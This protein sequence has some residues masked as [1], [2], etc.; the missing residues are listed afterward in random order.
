MNVIKL[1]I[2]R[3]LFMFCVMAAVLLLGI[4]L[5][6][7]VG[8]TYGRYYTNINQNVNFDVHSKQAAY[9][10]YWDGGEDPVWESDDGQE[11]LTVFVKNSDGD[12]VPT[13]DMTVRIRV[14]LPGEADPLAGAA[15][16]LKVE[17]DRTYTATH[18]QL[19]ESS[20]LYA[21]LGAGWVYTFIRSGEEV[22]HSLAGG[23]VSELEMKLTAEFDIDTTECIFIVDCVNENDSERSAN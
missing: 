14:F 9:V 16:K 23:E 20:A 11:S 3:Q 12:D 18:E 17:G 10:T 15:L 13:D 19:G 21:K 1:N 7:S 22:T 8:I 2:R 4:C 6:M 5:Q